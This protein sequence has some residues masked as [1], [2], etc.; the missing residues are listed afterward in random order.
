MFSS[1]F[2]PVFLCFSL[3][4]DILSVWGPQLFKTEVF[5]NLGPHTLGQSVLTVSANI[6]SNKVEI[7]DFQSEISY[8][9]NAK[10]SQPYNLRQQLT[11]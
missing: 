1:L 9:L 3:L 5:R 2:Q 10:V 4:E 7:K 8:N 11:L 6:A